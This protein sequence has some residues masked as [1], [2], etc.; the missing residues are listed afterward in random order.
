VRV[1]LP[2]AL[3][4]IWLAHPTP[5]ALEIGAPVALLGLLL[6][7]AAASHLKKHHGLVASGPYAWTRHPLYLG[8][9]ILGAGFLLA[10]HSWFACGLGI[11]YFALFYTAAMRREDRKLHARHGRAFEEYA[12]R[13]PAFFPRLSRRGSGDLSPSW[14]LYRRNGEYRAALGLVGGFALLWLKMRFGA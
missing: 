13:V 12:A 7:A 11:G 4:Y 5:P 8:S 9:A 3:L 2:V 6:R 14:A 10:A 1:A